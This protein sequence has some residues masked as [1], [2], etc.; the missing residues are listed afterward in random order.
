[1]AL[2]TMVSSMMRDTM[3]RLAKRRDVECVVLAVWTV[4]GCAIAI[5]VFSTLYRQAI[6][7]E[8]GAFNLRCINRAQV[9]DKL[10]GEPLSNSHIITL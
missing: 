5:A 9:R 6:H 10:K 8:E 4:V 3:K 7:V 2:E 1:M